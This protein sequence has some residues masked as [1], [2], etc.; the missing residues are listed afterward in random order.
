M[1]HFSTTLA[2]AVFAALAFASPVQAQ[3]D[4]LCINR[5]G[6][7]TPACVLARGQGMAELGLAGWSRS[8]DPASVADEIV[9]GDA[10]LRVGLGGGTEIET[11]ITAYDTI[12]T[13]DR[14]SGVVG[15]VS[16]IGDATLALRHN[17]AGGNGPVAIEGF[18][19]VPTGTAGIGA[20]D[21]GGGVLVPIDV[22]L[23]D[24][25]GLAL[26]PEVDAAVNASGRGRHLAW[27]GVV[28]LGHG[29]GRRVAIS[30]ELGA[31]RDDDPTGHS[32]DG[33]AAVSLAWRVA[34]DWQLDLE[35]EVGLTS[36]APRHALIFG[37][38]RRVP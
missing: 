10:L 37:L 2:M 15:R 33:R 30:G 35:A 20:G 27:G 9:L 12:R 23:S 25:F 26:T 7:G 24:G 8:S 36:A 34:A 29:L 38:A 18:V 11:G 28:G 4:D 14:A 16:G 5:P 17:F 1:T 19:T 32:T 31:W 22:D 21:W 6:M 13:R 3:D